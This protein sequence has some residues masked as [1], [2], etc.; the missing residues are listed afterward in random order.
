VTG[1][2]TWAWMAASQYILG[3]RAEFDGLRVDPCIPSAWDGFTATRRF[4]GATYRI[5]VRNPRHA[6]RG[7]ARMTVNGRPIAGCIA[8]LPGRRGGTIAVEVILGPAVARSAA[9]RSGARRRGM[10]S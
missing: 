10:R 4:R 2:A 5:A 7:V 8:P 1:S 3:I 9:T 6:C